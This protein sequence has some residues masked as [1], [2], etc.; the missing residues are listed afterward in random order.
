MGVK[1]FSLLG[2]CLHSVG[3][4]DSTYLSLKARS[5][6]RKKGCL[7]INKIIEKPFK[8]F[9]I[10]EEERAYHEYF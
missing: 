3:G 9:E 5:Y 8:L 6:L 10:S 4:N 2:Y 1:Y 7:E